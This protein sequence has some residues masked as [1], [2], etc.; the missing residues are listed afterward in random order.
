[1]ALS[2]EE[3]EN[4]RQQML[5]LADKKGISHKEVLEC[6]QELDKLIITIMKK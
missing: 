3:I 4:K 6:S 5:E 1:M 2:L